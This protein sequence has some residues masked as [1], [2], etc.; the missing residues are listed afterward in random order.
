MINATNTVEPC[1]L[2][3]FL[4]EQHT[5]IAIR[6]TD[7]SLAFRACSS[8]IWTLARR[9]MVQGKTYKGRLCYVIL[10]A[11]MA[12]AM[13]VLRT[14]PPRD[15]Q[16]SHQRQDK[17]SPLWVARHDRAKGGRTGSTHKVVIDGYEKHREPVPGLLDE[18]KR[19]VIAERRIVGE[20]RQQFKAIICG[21]EM[22]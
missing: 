6:Y 19:P 21:E 18:Q 2:L 8:Q 11:S 20:I 9:G 1:A 3:P 22:L 10:I 14:D 17:G 4:P 13:R 5:E 15:R 12:A 16:V 7:G